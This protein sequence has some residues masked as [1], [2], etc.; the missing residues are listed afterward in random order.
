MALFEP[1]ATD[2]YEE[3]AQKLSLII[4]LKLS[5]KA[6]AKSRT[7]RLRFDTLHHAVRLSV[8]PKTPHKRIEAFV[9]K[10]QEWISRISEK[11]AKPVDSSDFL[12]GHSYL[13][14][15]K[16]RLIIHDEALKRAHINDS[17]IRCAGDQSLINKRIARALKELA[18]VEASESLKLCCNLLGVSFQSVRLFDAKGRWGSCSSQKRTIRI[19]WRLIFAPKA[20]FDYVCAHEAAHLIEAN[21]SAAFWRLVESLRPDYRAEEAWLKRNGAD[22]WHLKP[23]N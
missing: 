2:A 4:G 22:L 10:H 21:H 7:M 6:Y 14:L 16:P 19:H 17:E 18:F 15:G 23:H 12:A 3:V 13:I 8:P 1:I 5:I 11:S 9:L 20:V